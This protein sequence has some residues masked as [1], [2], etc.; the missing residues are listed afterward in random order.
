MSKSRQRKQSNY[1]LG[2]SDALNRKNIYKQGMGSAYRLG[3]I[4]GIA[5]RY[6]MS[7]QESKYWC[8][9]RCPQL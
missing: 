8:L 6:Y 5:E 4:H 2:V 7:F 9:I 3:Y 1:S